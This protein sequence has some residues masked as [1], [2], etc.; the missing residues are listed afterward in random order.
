MAIKKD[1]PTFEQVREAFDY[2][3]GFL[4]WKVRKRGVK[5]GSKA[6]CVSK[7]KK[8]Y[9]NVICINDKNI[10]AS[11]VIFLWHHGYLPE[12]V[13]HEDRDTLNDLIDNLRDADIFKNNRN[14]TSQKNSSSQYLGVYSNGMGKWRAK[15]KVNNKNIHLGTFILESKAALAYN[16]SAVKYWG[17]FAN[18][19]IIKPT[20][21]AETVVYCYP[22]VIGAVAPVAPVAVLRFAYTP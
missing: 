1:N 2:K 11:R 12:I 22:V 16:K 17:E 10:N 15:I 9:R 6:G 20:V 13:D 4:Y 8:G 5:L 14:K 19:N 21:V 18:L 3:D 7:R